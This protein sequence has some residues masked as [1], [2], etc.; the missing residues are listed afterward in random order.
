[1]RNPS[2]AQTRRKREPRNDELKD[3]VPLVFSSNARHVCTRA[4]RADTSNRHRKAKPCTYWL[5]SRGDQCSSAP[6]SGAFEQ[7]R[8]S[9]NDGDLS[10]ASGSRRESGGQQQPDSVDASGRSQVLDVAV[11]LDIAG[12]RNAIQRSYPKEQLEVEAD[13]GRLV[14]T[15]TASNAHIVEDLGKMAAPTLP[16]SSIRFTYPWLTNARWCS[17]SSLRR[18]IGRRYSSWELTISP[19]ALVT[20]RDPQHRTIWRSLDKYKFCGPQRPPDPRLRPPSRHLSYHH[21]TNP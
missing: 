8:R 19:Q 14:L 6:Y 11:D 5:A 1:M 10:D 3:C 21:I 4:R 13:A 2:M 17:R 16:K 12:L 20:Q 15:G 18:S 7:S 9:R